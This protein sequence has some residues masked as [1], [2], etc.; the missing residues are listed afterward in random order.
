MFNNHCNEQNYQSC[1]KATC[2]AI[3]GAAAGGTLGLFVGIPFSS[4]RSDSPFIGIGVGAALGCLWRPIDKAII[5][6]F[7]RCRDRQNYRRFDGAGAGPAAGPVHRM[8]P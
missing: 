3:G 2:E 6:C 4:L 1:K 7:R 8:G 5:F